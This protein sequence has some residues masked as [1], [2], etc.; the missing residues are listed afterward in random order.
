MRRI[1]DVCIIGAVMIV[2]AAVP[3]AAKSNSHAASIAG[4]SVTQIAL[5]EDK[6]THYIEA[7]P[8]FAAIFAKTEHEPAAAAD[9]HVLAELNMT[10]RRYGFA[11]YADYELVADNIVWILSGIDPLNRKYI[12]IPAVT[13]E[14]AANV[15]ADKTLSAK[16]HK[17]RIEV[18]H[19]QM[20]TAAPVKFAD[21]VA[22]I[23]K[24]YDQLIPAPQN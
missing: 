11:N 16:E 8:I 19:A 23:T 17:R 6:V 20:L 14:Q 22:L 5:S 21:N 7:R 18:L 13:H 24:Y 1:F 9:P 10:A 3:A 4:H 12:G 2:A 15:V